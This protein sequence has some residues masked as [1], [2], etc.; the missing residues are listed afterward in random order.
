[1]A[2]QAKVSEARTL[3]RTRRAVLQYSWQEDT[4]SNC[5]YFFAI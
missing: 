2:M 3:P 5:E 4:V 1:V